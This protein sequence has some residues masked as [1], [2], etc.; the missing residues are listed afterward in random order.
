MRRQKDRRA[1]FRAPPQATISRKRGTGAR[2]NT[3]SFEPS[4][5]DNC[6]IGPSRPIEPPE[7]IDSRE[8]RLLSKAVRNPMLPSPTKIASM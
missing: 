6:I 2:A 5:A 7:A 8:D 4:L 3:P 1:T